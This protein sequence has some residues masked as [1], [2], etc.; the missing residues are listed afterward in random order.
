MLRQTIKELTQQSAWHWMHYKWGKTKQ[1][2]G[3][4]GLWWLCSACQSFEVKGVRDRG[5]GWKTLNLRMLWRYENAHYLLTYLLIWDKACV[6]LGKH[7]EWALDRVRWS[8]LMCRNVLPVQAWK[9][10]LNGDDDADKFWC[11][12]F[13]IESIK[14]KFCSFCSLS[15]WINAVFSTL[16]EHETSPVKY[17]NYWK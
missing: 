11:I 1:T 15:T 2:G 17:Y 12:L 13:V 3:V 10:T 5:R 7:R 8:G 16:S 14:F 6:E 9:W 4:K